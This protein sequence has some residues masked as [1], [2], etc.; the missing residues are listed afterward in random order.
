M[1]VVTLTAIT[2]LYLSFGWCG[3][4]SFGPE[5][6]DLITMNLDPP[7]NGGWDW[8]EF[9]RYCLALALTFTYPVMLFPVIKMLK[10]R[11]EN[12]FGCSKVSNCSSKIL[13]QILRLSVHPW[14]HLSLFPSVQNSVTLQSFMLF[15]WPGEAKQYLGW[16]PRILWVIQ[17]LMHQRMRKKWFQF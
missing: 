6:H 10:P 2:L 1:F 15:R 3:Y 16:K 13:F 7:E 14:F 17:T 8:A 5:T 12:F 11:L 9:I 4:L